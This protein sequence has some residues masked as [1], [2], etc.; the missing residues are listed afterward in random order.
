MRLWLFLIFLFAFQLLNAQR[1]VV[2]VF[3]VSGIDLDYPNYVNDS[4]ESERLS[5]DLIQQLHAAAFLE[6]RVDS[7]ITQN[8]RSKIYVFQG[9]EYQWVNLSPGNL[10][11]FEVSQV[12]LN[13][14]LFLNRPFKPKQL[15][16]LFQRTVEY[17]ENHGYPFASVQLDSIQID[18]SRDMPMERSYT[19]RE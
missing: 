15:R 8:R 6:A 18:T 1:L 13:G 10:N 14:R 4:A 19:L 11:Q 16:K 2:E 3:G 7:V 5:D 9:K 12:D 17:Y